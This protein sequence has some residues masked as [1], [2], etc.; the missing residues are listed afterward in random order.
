[1]S[2]GE[3]VLNFLTSLPPEESK[4]K[5]QELNK[6]L[7]W[8]G[9][10]RPVNKI[11]PL[12]IETY[13]A[14]ITKSTGDAQKRLE[15]LKEF[16][17]YLKKEKYIKVGLATHLRAKKAPV[18]ARSRAA[19]KQ[20]TVLT[21]EDYEK[22]K[23]QLASLEEDRYHIAQDLRRAAADKD[24]RE[25]APLQ[26]AREQRDQIEARIR[27]I[28]TAM[29]TGVLVQTEEASEEAIVR[30][31]S[32]VTLQDITSGDKITY[33]LVTRNESDPNKSKISIVSPIGKA[34]LNQR[35][36]NQVKVVVPAGELHYQIDSVE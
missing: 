34:L 4:V 22:L 28:Q 31:G 17:V 5:Q 33:T 8:Y 1:M 16:F 23:T 14:W 26:A 9:K 36:G 10:D 18:K 25:N 24:F 20:E 15:P 3:A 32:K 13:G 21:P 6:F 19:V 12:E 7:L 27:S 35:Q 30:L 11:S 29:A 2:L